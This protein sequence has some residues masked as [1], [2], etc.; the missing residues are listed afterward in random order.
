MQN[1]ITVGASISYPKDTS[2]GVLN[3]L[4]LFRY[5][6]TPTAVQEFAVYPRLGSDHN[7]WKD[8]LLNKVRVN[9]YQRLASRGLCVT[10]A[11]L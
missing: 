7:L 8:L 2:E 10:E 11:S 9:E 3:N 6:S 4:H 5:R 1:V